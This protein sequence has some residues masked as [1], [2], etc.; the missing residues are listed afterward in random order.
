MNVQAIK[1]EVINSQG[2]YRIQTKLLGFIVTNKIFSIPLEEQ[3]Q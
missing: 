2:V 3:M 1:V